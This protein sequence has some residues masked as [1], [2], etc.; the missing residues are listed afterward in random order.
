MKSSSQ[1]LCRVLART[2]TTQTTSSFNRP[3]TQNV[4]R[5]RE[6]LRP[7]ISAIHPDKFHGLNTE[8]TRALNENSLKQLNGFLDMVEARSSST[9]G[10]DRVLLKGSCEPKYIFSFGGVTPKLVNVVV[11]IPSSLR[12][13]TSSPISSGKESKW[14][15]L[16][17]QCAVD[18][19][20]GSE[21]EVPNDLQVMT[22]SHQQH[23][24]RAPRRSRLAH[25]THDVAA[26]DV[27][28]DAA[29]ARSQALELTKKYL[30]AEIVDVEYREDEEEKE[31]EREKEKTA[32][33]KDKE[34][35][36][37]KEK[38]QSELLALQRSVVNRAFESHRMTVSENVTDQD[39]VLGT[40]EMLR[41]LLITQ[42]ENLQFGSPQWSN[43]MFLLG[44]YD[45]CHA[46][47]ATDSESVVVVSIPCLLLEVVGEEG[48]VKH[49]GNGGSDASSSSLSRDEA[50][51]H[52]V[53]VLQDLA[54][55]LLQR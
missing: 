41:G 33:E 10:I 49:V 32:A 17:S 9:S 8:K 28:R 20:S 50:E 6:L 27:G 42:Y 30:D 15:S 31:K 51:V 1:S 45:S 34:N 47:S 5:V 3:T 54:D 52:V 39:D 26:R 4:R 38:K 46:T 11:T 55:E 40:A 22:L 21:M 43:V 7:F 12:E 14:L 36:D 25:S 24:R 16:A 23:A 37:S 53:Q 2:F 18:L 48:G 44:N 35:V 29:W 13:S 19:L